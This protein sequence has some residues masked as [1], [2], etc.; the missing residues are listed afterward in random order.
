MCSCSHQPTLTKRDFIS[1]KTR[2]YFLYLIDIISRTNE[3]AFI[4]KF[5]VSLIIFLFFTITSFAQQ[6]ISGIVT[7]PTGSPL[8][9]ATISIRGS[10]IA[11]ATNADGSFIITVKANDVL[12]ISYVGYNTKQIAVGNETNLKIS[13]APSITDLD[14]VVVTGYTSQK[15]KEITG[16]VA[17]VRSKDLNAIPAGQIEEMLQGRVAGLNIVNSGQPGQGAQISLS[18]IGNFGDVRP[19]YIIDGV[20]GD[21]NSINPNDVESIQV[22][23]DAGSAAIYGVRGANGV[24]IVTTRR[25]R[26]GKTV[27]TYEAYGGTQRP[28]KD[29]WGLLDTK[30]R[31]ALYDLAVT[32]T[33]GATYDNPQYEPGPTATIPYYIIA[34]NKYGVTDPNDS[35]A[36]L[37]LYN[38]DYAAG[39]IYLI[40]KANQKG[41]DW[42]HE[43]FKPAFQTN[44]TLSVAGGTDKSRYLLS[45]GYLNQKGTFLHTYLKRY[46][47]RLN[48]DF[49]IKNNI[50][51]GEN[52]QVIYRDNPRPWQIHERNNIAMTYCEQPIIPVHDE[53]GGYGGTSALGLGNFPNPVAD[54]ERA[55]DDK[56]YDVGI[57]GNVYAEVDFLKNFRARTSFGGTFDNFYYYNFSFHTY[58]NAENNIVNGFSENAGFDRGW[59]WTN[60]LAF[61]K[62]FHN[63]HSVKLLGGIE[64]IDNYG[65]GVGAG[66][67]GFFLDDPNY[68][69]LSN[70]SPIGQTNYSY[71]NISSLYSIL[72]RLDYA[73]ADKYLFSATYR[74]DG[75]SIFGPDSRYGNFPSFSAAWRITKESFAKSWT[76]I[77]D[78]KLR[79]SWGKSGFAGNTS[80][81]N[82]FTLFGS[83]PD[84]SYYDITGSSTSV[85][86]GFYAT[87]IGNPRSGWQKDKKT[88]IGVDA[89]LWN[90]KLTFS[91]DYYS[92]EA[93]G[94][95][96][97]LALPAILGGAAAPN[98]NVGN[99]ENHGFDLLLGSKGTIGKDWMYDVAAT[100]STYKSNIVNIPVVP[101]FDAGDLHDGNAV[102]NQVGHPISTFFGYKVIGLFQDAAEATAWNQQDAAPGRFKYADVNG[103]KLI[104]ADDR[105]FIGD[106]NPEFSF[107]LNISITYK[108]FDFSTFMYGTFGN[109]VFNYTKYW[110]DL[111]Q[112]FE[113]NKSKRALTESWTPTRKGNTV[114]IQQIT[115]NFSSDGAVNSYYIEDGSYFRSKSLTIGY[116]LPISLIQKLGIDKVRVY[117]QVTNLFTI[118]KYSGL[119]PEVQGST[120]ATGI[121]YGN[122]P[123]NQK[124]YLFGVNITF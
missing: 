6:K 116:S 1:L 26:T 65:R 100:I 11:T 55:K 71:A 118:T 94:L 104:N 18:G 19:L 24:I 85:V 91:A 105:T 31:A 83:A 3:N 54:A 110:I 22:L 56:G 50:R 86:P 8:S 40:T 21:I 80:S 70:G 20:A 60:T 95:L 112:G 103:D 2:S 97:Q 27:I 44:H 69:I 107:G 49:S 34:G 9:G 46:T 87:R 101:Y 39:P 77:T 73:F 5:A 74:R 93:S 96:F 90:G 35:A 119:D 36:D 23:R 82:Q 58:E 123:A 122:Y 10:N 115:T 59:T 117:V 61:N 15:I 102:R 88:N 89:V 13:L 66:R 79:A 14:Q 29:G 121:D 108:Q 17:I 30:G 84:L 45:L 38:N 28:L 111:Y 62:V 68:R 92:K 33:P 106:P 72:A 51:I 43:C 76:S 81:I 4:K 32:N 37:S 124:Q 114:P 52:L 78:L 16:S 47:I 113:G 25:G 53:G 109:D 7:T 41:T 98:V 67:S 120:A 57:F 64:A 63:D 99:V 75:S 12:L 48:S 42:F